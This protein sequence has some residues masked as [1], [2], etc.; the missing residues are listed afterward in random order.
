M[1][2]KPQ[3]AIRLE[4]PE[5]GSLKHTV[6][7]TP[8]V[9]SAH[10]SRN[11][12]LTADELVITIGWEEGGCDPRLLK[13]STIEFYMW[14]ESRQTFQDYDRRY[15]RFV[16]VCIKAVRKLGEESSEVT[17]TFR[18]YTDIFI[19]AKP[20]PTDGMPEYSDTLL[21]IWHKIC[22]FTGPRDPANGKII[23]SVAVLRDNLVIGPGID[24]SRNLGSLVNKRFLKI[25]KPSPRTRGSAWDVWQ[26]CIGCLGYV[27]FIEGTTCQL[28]TTTEHYDP[29]NAPGLIY[30]ENILE[31]EEESD[32]TMSG[33]GILLKSMDP[34]TGRTLESAYPLP[35]DE[36]LK[37]TR[38]VVKHALKEGRNLGVN[39]V[40]GDFE[41]FYYP[42]IHDQKA[43]DFR[44]AQAYEEYSRQQMTGRIKTNEMILKTPDDKDFDILDIR[45][46]DPI[47]IGIDPS[48]RNAKNAEDAYQ[49]LV[50]VNHYTEGLARIVSQNYG[51]TELQS[52]TFHVT[53]MDVEFKDK[54][55]SI[56]IK[57]HN[58][59]NV[60]GGKVINVPVTVIS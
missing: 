48:I 25:H 10:W 58:L 6:V 5:A 47:S 14:D 41:E 1:Y 46:N 12:H 15:L 26:W 59:V 37:M 36:R 39:D 60:V 11:N 2:Y 40:S 30:G 9:I 57:Y 49:I 7:V 33:K 38:S 17:M 8:S 31:F 35:G 54:E 34:L 52:P 50:N 13:N 3:C 19:H 4:V 16:G 32:T 23:S 53:T 56:D 55:C 20:F 24:Q 51:N 45:A 21:E 42:D 22:D 44:A 29:R 28:M 18:D 43:L 27:S